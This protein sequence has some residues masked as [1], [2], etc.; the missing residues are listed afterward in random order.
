MEEGSGGPEIDARVKSIND[1]KTMRIQTRTLQC[2][3][4]GLWDNLAMCAYA[5]CQRGDRKSPRP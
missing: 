3:E 4:L 5:A 2:E 1:L